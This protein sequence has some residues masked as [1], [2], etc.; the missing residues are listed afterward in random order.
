MS[1][2]SIRKNISDRLLSN[3]EA[4]YAPHALDVASRKVFQSG[5]VSQ[6]VVL[7]IA[8][9]R[10]LLISFQ[11]ALPNYTLT[12]NNKRLYRK[13]VREHF[14][15]Q[16][17]IPSED[18][19]SDYFKQVRGNLE[20]GKSLIYTGVSHSTILRNLNTFNREF[21]SKY[22]QG[23]KY[24][25]KNKKLAL[26]HGKHGTGVTLLATGAVGMSLAADE[27]DPDTY[28]YFEEAVITSINKSVNIGLSTRPAVRKLTE[29]RLVHLVTNWHQLVDK[30]GK[31]LAGAALILT[32]SSTGANTE[33]SAFEKWEV[34]ILLKALKAGIKKLAKDFPNLEGSSSLK[35]K[36]GKAI[37]VD[38]IARNMTG[39]STK[40][41]L[42]PKLVKANLKTATTVK[43]KTKQGGSKAKPYKPGGAISVQTK[44]KKGQFTKKQTV[45]PIQLTALINAALPGVVASHMSPPALQY[46]TGTFARSAKVESMFATRSQLGLKYTYDKYPYQTFEPGF[47]QGS[48]Q[49]DPRKIIEGSIREIAVK[50]MGGRFPVSMERV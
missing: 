30:S 43:G 23:T 46:R 6:C 15:G 26:D 9:V 45:D 37:I 21:V 40:V 32:P 29:E 12:E 42:D 47:V 16:H 36:I 14:K 2:P 38:K 19:D 4:D 41:K 50:I 11:N 22:L 5:K 1:V 39:K 44:N 33:A 35:D 48:V 10:D 24:E 49:R 8:S 7:N 3:L 20:W 34:R 28:K 18:L 31:L 25:A 27:L 17:K 13:K